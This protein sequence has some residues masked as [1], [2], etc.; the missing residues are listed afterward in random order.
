[1]AARPLAEAE[2]LAL[3]A[4]RGLPFVPNVPGHYYAVVVAASGARQYVTVPGPLLPRLCAMSE[5]EILAE[6]IGI[7]R[8][9]VERIL[10]GR[11]DLADA[12]AGEF[13]LP[14][15]AGESDA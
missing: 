10:A 2:R 8:Q 11:R 5:T 6:Q 15:S 9:F 14:G 7:G 13:R 3:F 1:L 4:F 12:I